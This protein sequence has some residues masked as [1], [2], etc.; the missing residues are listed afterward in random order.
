M[1][2]PLDLSISFCNR[3]PIHPGKSPFAKGF[4]ETMYGKIGS[5]WKKEGNKVTYHFQIPANTR[6][7]VRI[8]APA[9]APNKRRRESPK[10]IRHADRPANRIRFRHLSLGG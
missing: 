9:G 7:N 6:A 10:G 1:K 3:P 2:I 5:E 8:L 4:V